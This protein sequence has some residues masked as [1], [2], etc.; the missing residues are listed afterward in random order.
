MIGSVIDGY[1]I[2]RL[3]GEGGMGQVFAAVELSSGQKVAVKTLRPEL[4]GDGE[5]RARFINEARAIK[6]VSHPGV[7]E[8]YRVGSLPNGGVYIAMEYL[9]G[10]SLRRTLNG[11]RLSREQLLRVAWQV[12]R[13]LAIV[14]DKKIIHRDLKPENI[15]LIEALEGEPRAKVLDFGI[16]KVS[17]LT[18]A[19]TEAQTEI[20]TRTG[21]VFGTLT[22]MSPEQ[23]GADGGISG[24][25][26]VYAL[27]VLLYELVAGRP[28]FLGEQ[29]SQVIGKHLFAE[30]KPLH[31]LLPDVSSDLAALIHA[32]LAKKPEQ[33]PSMAIAAEILSLITQGKPMGQA[34]ADALRFAREARTLRITP[35]SAGALRPGFWTGTARWTAPVAVLGLGGLALLLLKSPREVPKPL[36]PVSP[37]HAAQPVQKVK[38]V[39]RSEPTGASVVRRADGAVLGTTPLDLERSAEAG[40][41]EI[42]LRKPGHKALPLTLALNESISI[43]RSL[44]ADKPA[45][46]PEERTSTKTPLRKPPPRKIESKPVQ[47]QPAEPPKKEVPSPAEKPPPTI[48][49]DSIPFLK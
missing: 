11:K 44:E 24:K 37:V 40:T 27:G 30:P 7:C 43:E 42:E 20:R 31:E 2:V 18:E 33:R 34:Q 13:T 23:L 29:D 35:P 38:W 1:Q 36:A 28:P 41:L 48:T 10:E 14:H 21:S 15:M 49:N 22:Y 26:D 12:A 8:V 6:I 25:S 17:A 45:A 19:Q 3:I 32:M 9:E 16:A 4:A 47:P 39:I 46:K 5:M